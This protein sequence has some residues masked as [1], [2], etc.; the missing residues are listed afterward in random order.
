MIGRSGTGKTREILSA[1]AQTKVRDQIVIVPEQYS[2][3]MERALC[4]TGGNRVCLHAEVLSFSRLAARVFA[5]AGGLS[6][7]TLDQGGRVLLLRMAMQSVAEQLRLYARPSRKPAFL[8]EMLATIDE[9]KSCCITSQQLFGVG[10]THEEEGEKLRELGL[11]FGAYE[12]LTARQGADPRDRL[13]RL[14]QS[15]SDTQWAAGKDFY[16]DSFTDFTPQERLVISRL[17]EQANRV[18]VAL[19]CDQ[20]EETEDGDG[21]FSAARRT[22]QQLIGLAGRAGVAYRVETRQEALRPKAPALS[23]MERA[24]FAPQPEAWSGAVDGTIRLLPAPVPFAEVECVAAEI[25]RLVREEGLRFRDIAVTAGAFSEYG[26]LIEIV[27]ARFGIP[28]FLSRM[29]DI[30]DKPVMA[31]ITAALDVVTGGYQYEQVIRY[32]KLGFTGLSQEE[33]DLLENYAY[34]WALRGGRW[35]Q[36][37]DWSMHPRGFGL[38]FDEA[39]TAL[40]QRLDAARRQ[41]TAPLEH[42]R[43]NREK[44][45]RGQTMALYRFL[46]EIDLSRQLQARAD[47]LLAQ[48]EPALAAEYTQLWEIV[49]G[50]MD[51]AAV[52]LAD[53]PMELEE[54][55]G[56]FSLVLSAYDVGSIPVSLDRV[57]AGDMPR[58]T[59]K[60]CSVLFL[61]GA[62]DGV[63]P[64]VS[65]S[66]GLLSDDDRLL[67]ATCG[68]ETAPSLRDKLPRELTILGETCTLPDTRLNISWS[69][70]GPGGEER[71]P[72]FLVDRLRGLFPDLTFEDG[73]AYP[74]AA[75][76]AAAQPALELAGRIPALE[77]ALR[78]IPEYADQAAR[79][80]RCRQLARG[81]LTRPVTE[82]LYGKRVPLSASR[83]D[84][85]KSCHFSYFMRYGLRAQARTPAGFQAPEY[86]TF[87]HYVLEH[88]FRETT[89]PDHAQVK[90]VV[91]R[92]VAQV[93]GGLEGET[94]RFRYLFRRLISS[95]YAV[96][97]NVAQELA[98]SEFK[99]LAFE[100]SFRDGGALPPLELTADGLTIS[101]T[102]TVDRVDGWVR[103]GKL[104]LRVVDYKTGRKSFQFTDIWNG[105]GLQM[106]L[107]LFTLQEQGEALY[108][109]E[110]VPAGVLYLPARDEAVQGSR[111]MTQEER[112]RKLDAQLRRRGLV[113]DDPDVLAAME[114]VS[115]DGFRFLPLRMNRGGEIG[116]DAL[117][118]QPQLE[119][120]HRHTLRVLGEIGAELAAGTIAADPVWKH[121]TDNA[122]RW[123]E[124][125]EACHFED[126]RGEDRKR[127]VAAMPRDEFWK[128]L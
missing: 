103:D 27:F 59:H 125:A 63:I 41:V 46:E 100:L 113:L 18:T 99:P 19:T 119:R 71:R 3:D 43:Q 40:L 82:A 89:T 77:A 20:L 52:I 64:Q 98:V 66:P 55:S 69:R 110:I 128:N 10:E 115:P 67:L 114:Q 34:R 126:G 120:L 62:D 85:V 28:V 30:L 127:Y 8:R 22:A 51:Q 122:C 73:E 84:M 13:T 78:A 88:V 86:G 26:A 53:T 23:Y 91:D 105:I 60:P 83:M 92:Y 87:I 81:Q 33:A 72:C 109:K 104:Y 39:D 5:A 65:P 44:T 79:I 42:L 94:P 54:F 31:V 14:S 108:G 11:I 47:A 74:C 75:R 36:Q 1:A 2:H 17:L 29:T 90:A 70:S 24:L 57:S 45:G 16:I 58:L 124:Y 37:A 118:Q 121:D 7:A 123:C 9:F 96:V 111:G 21:I 117:V 68:L 101:V 38:P 95:V 106:L 6:A 116:G 4:K 107:Y 102:G 80:T 49:C 56:L 50:A 48:G 112:R 97:E 76:L 61:L 32:G 15:L 25:L 12:A 35:T 93:L